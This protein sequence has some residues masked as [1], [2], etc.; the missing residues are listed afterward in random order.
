MSALSGIQSI[1][2]TPVQA[3]QTDMA[4]TS[5][6]SGAVTAVLSPDKGAATATTDVPAAQTGDRVSLSEAA[7]ALLPGAQPSVQAIATDSDLPQ[8]AASLLATATT[9]SGRQVRIEQYTAGANPAQGKAASSAVVVTV[10]A[11]DQ[12]AEQRYLVTDDT[13][14]NENANGELSVASYTPGRETGGNDVIIG[15]RGLAY[16]GG[17]GN[18]TIVTTGGN[19]AIDAGSGNDTVVVAGVAL[20]GHISMGDGNDTLTAGTIGG[21]QV[22]IDTGDGNDTISASYIGLGGQVNIDTGDGDDAVHASWIGLGIGTPSQVNIDT[23]AGNDSVTSSW[24]GVSMGSGSAQV[25]IDTG[26]GNDVVG[27][28]WVSASF[29]GGHS[30]TN[31]A[32]GAGNDTIAAGVLTASFFGGSSQT[33]ID[34]GSGKDTISVGLLGLQVGHAS[35]LELMREVVEEGTSDTTSGA[36]TASAAGS[37]AGTERN[38]GSTGTGSTAFRL[39]RSSYASQNDQGN[40]DGQT[41]PHAGRLTLRGRFF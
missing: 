2:T 16:Q 22:N 7:K 15:V 28:S 29:F 38:A 5:A 8:G 14:I 3:A 31:I 40:K 10:S 18:D 36:S 21:G 23:G 9:E 27:S 4:N 17:D 35:R 26:D 1:V 12:Q 33:N 30:Q 39:A 25:N 20:A 11:T 37:T 13:I 41:A 32:T 24:T 34:T 19:V 6:D